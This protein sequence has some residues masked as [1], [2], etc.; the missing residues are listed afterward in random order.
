[1]TVDMWV[2]NGTDYVTQN[3]SSSNG[4]VIP[5]GTFSHDSTS[6]KDLLTGTLNLQ[7]GEMNDLMD[8]SSGYE[9]YLRFK[10]TLDPKSS[11]SAIL[12]GE[13]TGFSVYDAAGTGYELTAAPNGED[14]PI[15]SEFLDYSYF[16]GE[17]I[18]QCADIKAYFDSTESNPAPAAIT[19][20][21]TI[22]ANNNDS[23][24]LDKYYYVKI[25]VNSETLETAFENGLLEMIPCCLVFGVNM[26]LEIRSWA[27]N[28]TPLPATTPQATN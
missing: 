27:Y 8:F 9:V 7:F 13:T 12:T 28:T 15:A 17:Y 16:E 20:S 6:N 23:S 18:Q 10:A 4:K 19:G 25:V 14:F 11:N 24:A 2:Y 21:V 26:S 3:P 5:V 22:N 1:M